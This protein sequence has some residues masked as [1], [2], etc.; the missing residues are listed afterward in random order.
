MLKVG[1]SWP[2]LR[3]PRSGVRRRL[4]NLKSSLQ[5]NQVWRPT[6][7]HHFVFL[8]GANRTQNCGISARRAAITEFAARFLPNTKIFLAEK[9]F[10]TLLPEG[11][12]LNLLDTERSLTNFAD[13]ILIVLESGSAFCEL[14][15]FSIDITLR[16]KIVVVNDSQYEDVTSF[17]NLGPLAAIRSANKE[18]ILSYKMSS[19]G[20]ETIDGIGD[21][22]PKLYKI[23]YRE[24]LKKRSR[25]TIDDCRPNSLLSKD[26]F[27]FL[28]DI[29]YFTQPIT[30]SEI[31]QILIHIFGEGTYDD[32]KRLLGLLRAVN[33]LEVHQI[34]SIPHYV[35]AA[36]KPYFD[37]DH[38]DK[39]SII[40]AFRSRHLRVDAA[41]L[42]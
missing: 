29:V 1:K 15:A 8:C 17:I 6:D 36:I 10:E 3:S 19:Q 34:N 4:D 9:V 23:L 18:F 22:F 7:D 27:R 16:K 5:N 2:E 21:I 28:H 39:T 30:H 13:T 37:Y 24:T 20:V 26:A 31:I 33:E 41:R 12:K 25:V 11:D 38:L 32:V 40:A 35:T 42:I 14:G